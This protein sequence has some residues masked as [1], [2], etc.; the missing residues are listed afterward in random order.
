MVFLGFIMLD[1]A[2][3]VPRNRCLSPKHTR[4]GVSRFDSSLRTTSIPLCLATA[5]TQLSFPRSNPT[6]LIFD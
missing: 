1:A 5:T 4:A 6:T 2:P 3:A